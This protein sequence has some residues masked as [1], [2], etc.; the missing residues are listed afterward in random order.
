MF[1]RPD[2][3]PDEAVVAAVA[4]GWDL[5]VRR[6]DHVPLGFGSH[7]WQVEID[8][9]ERRFVT[10]DDLEAKRRSPTEP[11]GRPR[12]RLDAALSAACWLREAGL[13]FV[14]AP[15]RTGTGAVLH[16]LD[17]RFAVAVYPFVD[18]EAHPWGAYPTPAARAVLDL[19]ATLHAAPGPP[20]TALVD[21]FEVPN[22]AD[23]LA[24]LDHLDAPWDTGPYGERARL[25]FARHAGSIPPVLDHY[26]DLVARAGRR[27]ERLVL[28][29]GEPHRGNTMDTATGPVLIDWET[30]LV[31]PPERDLWAMAV[32]D[33]GVLDLYAA[34][35]GVTPLAEAVELYRLWWDLAEVA[36]G[37]HRFHNPHRESE[38]TVNS[39]QAFGLYLDPGRWPRTT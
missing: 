37:V 21:D 30:A 19:V 2:D 28:T 25:H 11:L 38:D 5:R 6:I 14:V 16:E 32:E 27:P 9:G 8:G 31:A 24:A 22:R 26:D 35:T 20:P 18:G 39:W 1:T 36:I 29:H 12:Q 7:H 33:P 10:A 23:L 34:R 17:E 3:L 4:G 13:P 15:L